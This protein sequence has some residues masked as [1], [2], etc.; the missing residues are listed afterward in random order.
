MFLIQAR[1]GSSRLPGK[2]LMRLYK[3]YSLLEII[4][5]RTLLSKYATKSNIV[6]L[7]S[8]EENDEP[9]YN[10]CKDKNINCFRGPNLNVRERYLKFFDSLEN[11]PEYF[12]RICADNPFLEPIFIDRMIEF[13]ENNK[14][15]DYVSYMTSNN[16]PSIK[17][18]YGFF[19]ELIKTKTFLNIN[20]NSL[21]SNDIEHI[22][23]IFYNNT[24]FNNYFFRIEEDIESLKVKLSIDT[25]DDFNYCKD[26]FKKL[27]KIDFTYLEVLNAIR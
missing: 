12:I 6:I 24:I 7:T 8:T 4:Y 13:Y 21:S 25:I 18:K 16:I 1:M 11:L 3:D 26:I 9:I 15:Y 10:F 27:N 19:A 23:P 5:L 14:L 22:T 2:S 20:S 17:T